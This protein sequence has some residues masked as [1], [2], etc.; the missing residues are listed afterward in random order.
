MSFDE[1]RKLVDDKMGMEVALH[2]PYKF[3]DLKPCYGVIFADRLK[4]YD[5][6]AFGDID[7]IY[8]N[9]RRFF[10]NEILD[11][12]TYISGFGHLTLV[13]NTDE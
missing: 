2:N 7:L 8:G 1:C 11:R 10:T 5:Y 6:W 9:I 3:C 4:E 12:Y 13:R